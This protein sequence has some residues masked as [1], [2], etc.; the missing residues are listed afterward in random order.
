MALEARYTD[1]VKE[2]LLLLVLIVTI[3]RS[4]HVSIVSWRARGAYASEPRWFEQCQ[5]K[6]PL[7]E[8]PSV[9]PPTFVG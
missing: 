1:L 4:G 5:F 6:P 9:H 7:P 3:A 8:F 2:T